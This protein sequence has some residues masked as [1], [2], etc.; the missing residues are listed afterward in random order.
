M[1]GL[2]RQ[3]LRPFQR[4]LY[5]FHTVFLTAQTGKSA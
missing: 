3:M 2:H 4:H 5:R 1:T